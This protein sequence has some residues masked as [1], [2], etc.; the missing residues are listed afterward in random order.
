MYGFPISFH[1][2][3]WDKVALQFTQITTHMSL[4][5]VPCVKQLFQFKPGRSDESPA[6]YRPIHF[7]NCNDKIITKLISNRMAKVLPDLIHINQTRFIQKQTQRNTK[8]CFR[9]IKYA[10]TQ[11]VD[12]SI[13][14]V[15]ADKAFNHLEWPFFFT[16][17]SPQMVVTVLSHRCN[18]RT[19]S[20]ETKVKSRASSETQPSRAALLLDTM[21][22]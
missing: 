7:I 11:D 4:N 21:P 6:D 20:G 13:M 8:T 22:A 17:F 10:N 16:L 2:I 19:D 15:D 18:S 14:S 12:T 3:F 1:L 9:K 5:S